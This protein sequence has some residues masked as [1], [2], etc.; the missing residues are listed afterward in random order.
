MSQMITHRHRDLLGNDRY[1]EPKEQAMEMMVSVR[2]ILLHAQRACG[3]TRVCYLDT[4]TF[5]PSF[6]YQL[7]YALSSSRTH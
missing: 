5:V 7:L 2:G 6:P 1:T 4:F 3:H